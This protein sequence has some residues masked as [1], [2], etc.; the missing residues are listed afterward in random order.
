MFARILCPLSHSRQW[1]RQQMDTTQHRT[2]N[3]EETPTGKGQQEASSTN[4]CCYVIERHRL[5]VSLEGYTN[6]KKI[7]PVPLAQFA[8]NVDRTLSNQRNASFPHE[9]GQKSCRRAKR[10]LTN[11]A[12]LFCL[13]RLVVSSYPFGQSFEQGRSLAGVHPHCQE[14]PHWGQPSRA[15]PKNLQAFLW[16]DGY[17]AI[18]VVFILLLRSRGRRIILLT[19][20]CGAKMRGKNIYA[21]LLLFSC[22]PY[23]S[24]FCSL[25]F[26]RIIFTNVFVVVFY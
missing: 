8:R 3:K 16:I 15:Y 22:V 18:V 6:H 20:K 24:C 21:Y 7:I 17:V 26:P 23:H 19:L 25:L 4:S 10:W 1:V 13:F 5:V 12:R 2:H 11:G 9:E 14:R